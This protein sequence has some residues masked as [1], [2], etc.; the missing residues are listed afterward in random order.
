LGSKP[1]AVA[2]GAQQIFAPTASHQG[3]IQNAGVGPELLEMGFQARRALPRL[4]ALRL[5]SGMTHLR[6][7]LTVANS[8]QTLDREIE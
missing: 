8:L 4:H 7:R 5:Y 3:A 1:A 6:R 2:A